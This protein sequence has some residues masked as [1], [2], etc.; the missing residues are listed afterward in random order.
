MAHVGDEI[1]PH[2]LQALALGHVAEHR[3]AAA[4]GPGERRHVHLEGLAPWS[5][6]RDLHL[7][8]HALAAGPQHRVV[9][10]RPPE[11]EQRPLAHQLLVGAEDVPEGLVVAEH[12]S[13][14]VGDPDSLVDR[15]DGRDESTHFLERTVTLLGGLPLACLGGLLRPVHRPRRIALAEEGHDEA[16]HRRQ[17]SC[18]EPR[19]HAAR[20]ARAHPGGEAG[21]DG[22]EEEKRDPVGV[23]SFVHAALSGLASL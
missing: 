19:L 7:G 4:R 10:L 18:E 5:V 23:C 15:L 9:E 1:L 12:H 14:G 13:L 20:Q 21:K 8:G 16:E 6:H 22:G 2:P 3:R 11:Q 17:G